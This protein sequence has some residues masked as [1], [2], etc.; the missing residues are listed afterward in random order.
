MAAIFQDGCLVIAREMNDT[1]VHFV[2]QATHFAV[3]SGSTFPQKVVSHAKNAIWP[4][5][6]N[7]AAGERHFMCF[8]YL[9]WDWIITFRLFGPPM[10]GSQLVV[11]CVRTQ[12]CALKAKAVAL[13]YL[14][15][16]SQLWA[17]GRSVIHTTCHTSSFSL[18]PQFAGLSVFIWQIVA[19]LQTQEAW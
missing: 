2:M 8:F 9:D 1:I 3:C 17:V 11:T 18:H 6:S 10:S 5:F 7:M 16:C 4:P 19:W 13:T 14:V 15:N 12:L